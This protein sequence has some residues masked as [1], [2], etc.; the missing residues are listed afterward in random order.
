MDRS[1]IEANKDLLSCAAFAI[2]AANKADPDNKG[3]RLVF[4]SGNARASI[5]EASIRVCLFI[6]FFI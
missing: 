2:N 1:E 4:A 3:G 5:V 6:V